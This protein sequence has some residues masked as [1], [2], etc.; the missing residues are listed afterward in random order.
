MAHTAVV[1]GV[2]SGLG[3][4][5]VRKLVKE[6][7]QVGMFARSSTYIRSLEQELNTKETVVRGLTTDISDPAQVQRSFQQTRET[8]GPIDLLINH[9]GNA[10]WKEFMA[11]TPEDFEQ[12][13]RV[14]AYGS[15]LCT[16]EAVTDM[17]RLQR[18]TILFSGA[19]SSIRGR[20]SAL[21]FSSAK[22]AV[23][24]LAESLARELWPQNIHVAHVIIDGAIDTPDLREKEST[25]S[26]DPLLNP[27]E[28]AEAYWSLIQQQKNAW[29]LELDLRPFNEDFFT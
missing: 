23:R 6:G 25:A 13:W 12:S 27:D 24:G 28:M 15:F 29:S 7:C 9:A 14:C 4:S 20:K 10:A 11:L 18:G 17:M 8:F 2:G 5:L 16:Q 26:T 3:A 21:A 22:F 1:T 19:T